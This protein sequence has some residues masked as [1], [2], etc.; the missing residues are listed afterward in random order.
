[1]K[2]RVL[3]LMYLFFLTGMFFVDLCQAEEISEENNMYTSL[4]NCELNAIAQSRNISKIEEVMQN[5]AD[6]NCQ[7]KF[8]ITSLMIAAAHNPDAVPLLLNYGA[9]PN[10]VDQQGW[11]ALMFARGQS[12]ISSMKYLIE[13]GADLEK[14][15]VFCF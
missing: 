6:I 1:M 14:R 10:L 8:G 3:L 4:P 15:G 11:T 5:G 12:K 13:G 2:S 9:N 7:N